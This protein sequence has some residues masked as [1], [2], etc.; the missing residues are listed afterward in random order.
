MFLL[1]NKKLFA[2]ILILSIIIVLLTGIL[3]YY[4]RAR[5]IKNNGIAIT[6]SQDF[7][8]HKVTYF[9][10]NDDDWSKDKI[11]NSS[12][13]MGSTGCLITCVASAL[14]D[15]GQ[16]ITPK[17]LNKSL[18][19]VNGFEGADLIWYKINEIIPEVEY[20]YNRIFSGSTIENDLKNNRLPI[21]NV[22]FNGNGVTHWVIV[23]GAKDGEF[24]IYDPANKNKMPIP[25]STHGKVFAYR[26]LY[27]V[28]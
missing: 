1:R 9:L 7:P 20:Q 16:T 15:L 21:V 18:S 11:G 24:L 2:V 6:P 4:L 12:Y 23:V 17:E 27:P 14:K 25:L 5:Y 28:Q 13:V 8:V 10:Q 22:R 26:V 19:S 3:V